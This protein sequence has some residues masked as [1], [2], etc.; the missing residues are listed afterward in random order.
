MPAARGRPLATP[1]HAS[2]TVKLPE[3]AQYGRP[4]T[5]NETGAANALVVRIDHEDWRIYELPPPAYDRRA[6]NTL[7]FESDG[8]I[9]RIQRFPADWRELPIEALVALSWTA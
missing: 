7:V 3:T 2:D 8:V 5:N 1:L 4:M 6:S 9:R